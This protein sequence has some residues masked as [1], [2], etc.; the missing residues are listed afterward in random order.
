MSDTTAG[1]QKCLNELEGA[2]SSAAEPII[3]ELLS[4]AYAR[5][6]TLCAQQLYG[7]YSRLAQGPHN[8]EVDEVLGGAVERLHR[9]LC[10]VRPQSLRHFYSIVSLQARWELREVIRR[11]RDKPAGARLVNEPPQAESES[12][13][14]PDARRMLD[15]IDELREDAREAFDLVRMQGL[16]HQEAADIVGV[17]TKTI[18]RRL[19]EAL[20]ELER[21]LL[22]LRPDTADSDDAAKSDSAPHNQQDPEG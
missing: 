8:L 4:R 17:S 22:D 5:I 18:Q 15:A 6:R 13:L 9:V 21:K 1:I 12:G 10:K 3:Q 7:R 20:L 11:A 16:S 19:H 14:T 2:G